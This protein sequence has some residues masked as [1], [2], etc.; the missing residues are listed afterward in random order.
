MQ[1]HREPVYDAAPVLD[2]VVAR[3]LSRRRIVHFVSRMSE[4]TFLKVGLFSRRKLARRCDATA[5]MEI[6]SEWKPADGWSFEETRDEK[7][8]DGEE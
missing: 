3:S 1:S 2:A 8:D 6:R 7:R 4:V 5:T